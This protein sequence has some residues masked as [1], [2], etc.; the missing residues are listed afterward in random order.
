MG[1]DFP[2]GFVYIDE[3]DRKR[4]R[5]TLLAQTSDLEVFFMR[6]SLHVLSLSISGT[7]LLCYPVLSIRFPPFGF[8]VSGTVTALSIGIFAPA[9]QSHRNLLNPCPGTTPVFF[10]ESPVAFLVD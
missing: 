1:N 2:M 8:K 3:L 6:T 10:R 7:V 5:H 4:H 9:C